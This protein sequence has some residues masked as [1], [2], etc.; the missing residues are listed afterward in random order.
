MSDLNNTDVCEDCFGGSASLLVVV[1]VLLSVIWVVF[2]LL[3][4]SWV[5]AL[6]ITKVANLFLQESGIYIGK[7]F[8]HMWLFLQHFKH[9]CIYSTPT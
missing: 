6:L 9:F 5:L 8:S 7:V 1:P 2:Q 4:S 3:H